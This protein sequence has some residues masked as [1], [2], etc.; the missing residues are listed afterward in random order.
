MTDQDNLTIARTLLQRLAEAQ[1]SSFVGEL[2]AKDVLW[3]IPGN[4]A[5]YP[6]IGKQRGQEAVNRF[7][8][9]TGKRLQRTHFEVHDILANERR[10]MIYGELAAIDLVTEKSMVTPFVIT[11][12]IVDGLIHSFLMME[13]SVA[14]SE[15]SRAD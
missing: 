12:D 15:A 13:N 10:A 11:L 14:V 9:E 6:W 2:F 7:I 1:S 4:E 5:A 8:T 3:H